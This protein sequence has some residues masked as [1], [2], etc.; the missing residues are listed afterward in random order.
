MEF[1]TYLYS[2]KRD[3]FFRSSKPR[4]RNRGEN[5]YFQ[6]VSYPSLILPSLSLE[7]PL[8]SGRI[9]GIRRILSNLHLILYSEKKRKGKKKIGRKF[10]SKLLNLRVIFFS[11]VF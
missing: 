4:L 11:L 2:D 6:Q 5:F 9:S 7:R 8:K 1:S 3:F 10:E